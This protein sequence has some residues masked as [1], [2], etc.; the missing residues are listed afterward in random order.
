ME[1]RQL[2]RSGLRVSRM[3]LGTMSWGSDTDAEEAASQLVVFVDA[4]GTLV[5]TADIYAE[6]ECERILGSLIADLVPRDDLVIATKAVARRT[7]GPFGGGASRGAL[8]TALDGSLRRLGTD[9]IDL[10]QLHAWD[11][12][13]PLEETLSALDY[14]VSSGKVRYTG[15]SNYAGWQLA[16][17]AS[18]TSLVSTQVEYSLVERGVER[19]VVPA[20]VH[21]GIGLLPWAPLGRGV[22]TGKYRTGTPA[23]SRGAS[24]AYA[25]YVE[26][27]RTDRAARIVEAVST[28]AD[29]LGTSPLVVALAWVRDRPGVVAPVVGARDTG[30]LTGSLAAEEIALP[31]AIKAALDDV[32]AIQFGY[33]ER[34]PK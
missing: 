28:A 3:A 27:H 9:H 18:R 34:W 31:H 22:L 17:A 14:A 23:D 19:E 8:L 20:A 29:G 10:W 32:S 15:V 6:G 1:K 21:H 13:V 24:P 26:Q 16:T 7:D 11:A 12:S 30:Q 33:P 2:G 4:G 5:D 25:G